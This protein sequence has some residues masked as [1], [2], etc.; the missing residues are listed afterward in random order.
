DRL[1]HALQAD[2]RGELR[3]IE[4]ADRGRQAAGAVAIAVVLAVAVAMATLVTRSIRRVLGKATADLA[5]DADRLGSLAT[6]VSSSS[7]SL[8]DGTTEQAAS[9]EETSASL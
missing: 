4:E 5:A 1:V 3:G 6:Q 2:M 9:L 7:Q 8:A